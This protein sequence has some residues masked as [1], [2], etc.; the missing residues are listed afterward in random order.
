MGT[1]RANGEGSIYF[2]KK[3]NCWEGQF[4]YFDTVTETAKKKK[5]TGASK[6]EVAKRGKNFIKE[7]KSKNAAVLL[8]KKEGQT[9]SEWLEKW[10]K[11][12]ILDKVKVKTYERYCCSINRHI[13][14]Y[15]GDKYL[16]QLNTEE[17]QNMLNHLVE[18]G[19]EDAEGL[20]ARTVNG[21]R[22]TL[23]GALKKAVDLELIQRNPALATVPFKIEKAKVEVLSQEESKALLDAAKM[24][25][26]VP[27]MVILLALTTGM[28]IGEI[29]GLHWDGVDLDKSRLL[30]DRTLV[31]TNHGYYLQATPKTKSSYRSIP[32][33]KLTVDALKKY[34]EWQRQQ[35][36]LLMNK[37]DDENIVIINPLGSYLDPSRFSFFTFKKVLQNAGIK[38]KFRFHDLRHTH[39]TLLLEQGI[40]I[41]VV[42]ER[43]GHSTI[44]ITLDTYS[45]VVKSMQDDAV[46]VIQQLMDDEKMSKGE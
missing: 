39:A 45:H 29:F 27:Y 2:N 12:F 17:I 6:T 15:I 41:K 38:R 28:R 43:I 35:K 23:I 37:Y 10:L 46:A 24:E 19:G 7:M 42:S 36:A 40:N 26:E 13:I 5:L 1:R 31:S 22:R 30:V 16:S 8:H 20:S 4:L 21:A 3:R 11:T 18:S 33:P 14:P 34:R 25:G 44:R 32:L 9:V